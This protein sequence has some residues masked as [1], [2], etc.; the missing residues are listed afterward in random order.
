MKDYTTMA[1]RQRKWMLY[2]LAISVIGWGFTDY[3]T[4]F[5]GLILGLAVGLFNLMLLQN[6]INIVAEKASKNQMAKSFGSLS[7][8][9]GAALVIVISMR[10]PEYF[11]IAASIFGLMAPYVVIMIDFIF[12]L[13]DISTTK[14]G[15]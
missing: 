15:E 8:L 5:A 3:Q 13:K 2:L 12:H 4:I 9:A 10:F 14:R 11:N 6:R 7:R 1:N